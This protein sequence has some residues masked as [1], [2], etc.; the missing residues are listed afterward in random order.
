MS[1]KTKNTRRNRRTEHLSD[2][3]MLDNALRRQYV[4]IM[5][6]DSKPKVADFL[7]LLEL[8]HKLKLGEDGREKILEII[9]EF[10]QEELGKLEKTGRS[11][12]DSG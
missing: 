10:R 11:K 1:G 9:D 2:S 8:K 4:E 12:R 7:K 3:E 5:S 6:D